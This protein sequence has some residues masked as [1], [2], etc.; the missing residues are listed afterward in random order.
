M[1]TQPGHQ[2]GPVAGATVWARG[3][4]RRWLPL[5]RVFRLPEPAWTRVVNRMES[6]GP[7]AGSVGREWPLRATAPAS[8]ALWRFPGLGG[9]HPASRRA[10]P[11]LACRGRFWAPSRACNAHIFG[12]SLVTN[13]VHA[14][15]TGGVM[16]MASFSGSACRAHGRFGWQSPRPLKTYAT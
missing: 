6:G 12:R 1:G 7:P 2:P 15:V 8:P 5:P 16:F 10:K 9:G 14:C 11:F 13:G 3:G 4:W